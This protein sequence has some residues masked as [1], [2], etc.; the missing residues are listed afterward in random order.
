[1]LHLISLKS[2]IISNKTVIFYFKSARICS[3]SVMFALTVDVLYFFDRTL[4]AVGSDTDGFIIVLPIHFFA[5]RI[6]DSS[7]DYATDI[8]M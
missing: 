4:A 7:N 3:F 6:I 2:Y 1:M 8:A 5:L